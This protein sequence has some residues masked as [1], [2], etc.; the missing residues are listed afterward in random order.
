MLQASISHIVPLVLAL[1][2]RIQLSHISSLPSNALPLN[3]RVNLCVF[4]LYT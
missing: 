4:V 2:Q 1:Y 3:V